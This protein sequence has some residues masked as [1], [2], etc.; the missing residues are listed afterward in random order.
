MPGATGAGTTSG[1]RRALPGWFG[2]LT[3]LGLLGLATSCTLD[4][5]AMAPSDP[6][7]VPSHQDPWTQPTQPEQVSIP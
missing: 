1:L 4:S 5:D 7:P 3:G 2:V 6:V